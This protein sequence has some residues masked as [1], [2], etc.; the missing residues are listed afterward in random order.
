M[1]NGSSDRNLWQPSKSFNLFLINQYLCQNKSL[2]KFWQK[3]QK[4]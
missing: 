1:K 4:D 3:W 2:Q